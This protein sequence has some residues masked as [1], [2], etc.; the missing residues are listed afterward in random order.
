MD[1]IRDHLWETWL[2]LSIG[3]GVAE[4]FSLDLILAM[5]AAGA[6]IGMVAALLGLPV[7]VQVLAALA[8]STAML[9]FVRPAF[10]KRLHGGPELSLGHGKLVG[11]RGLVTEEITGLAP[12]RIKAG[13]ELWTALPYD[14]NLRIAPGETVEILQIKGATA[15]VHPVATLEP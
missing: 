3:L 12:G 6:V 15:Y 11:T 1:W 10:V 7:V 8:A 14:E 9:A 4:M 13:G 5:L 2:A